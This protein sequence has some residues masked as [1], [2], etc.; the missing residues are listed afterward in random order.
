[1]VVDVDKPSI[2]GTYFQ[3]KSILTSMGFGHI[4]S[5]VWKNWVN[6]TKANIPPN[7]AMV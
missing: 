7:I 3:T 6:N 4:W 1:M 5:A 2:I